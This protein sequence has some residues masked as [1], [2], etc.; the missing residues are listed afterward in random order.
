MLRGEDLHIS[1]VQGEGLLEVGNALVPVSLVSSNY[2]MIHSRLAA[3]GY[4]L[5]EALDGGF[6]SRGIP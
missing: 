6:G 5:D 4:D 2:A 1:W 3:T